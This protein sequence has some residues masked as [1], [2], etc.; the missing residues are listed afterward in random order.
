MELHT[1]S[2]PRILIIEDDD[3]VAYLIEALLSREGFDVAIKRDGRAALNAIRGEP[4]ADIVVCDLMLPHI[5]GYHLISEIRATPGWEHTPIIVLSSMNMEKHVIKALEAG[6]NEYIA[7]PF[8]PAEFVA[9]LR[10]HLTDIVDK[11]TVIEPVNATSVS[12]HAEAT[13]STTTFTAPDTISNNKTPDELAN[14]ELNQPQPTQQWLTTVRN[15]MGPL[16]MAIAGIAVA[17]VAYIA[18]PDDTKPITIAATTTAQVA[19][20]AVQPA[21]IE[22]NDGITQPT[23]SATRKPHDHRDHAK[24]AAPAQ[25]GSP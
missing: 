20:H 9:R 17:V 18:G 16:I 24:S 6:A 12:P 25:S 2:P 1:A 5:D 3:D 19:E 22:P 15:Q 11:S 10:R 7:K 23:D 8:R 14:V 4:P 21:S 13:A